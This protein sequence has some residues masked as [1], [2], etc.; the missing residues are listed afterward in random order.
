[1]GF[2]T[3]QPSAAI[4]VYGTSGLVVRLFP[5]MTYRGSKHL[6]VAEGIH[7]GLCGCAQFG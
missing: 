3:G 2:A 7:F 4:I 1:M 5:K 6:I